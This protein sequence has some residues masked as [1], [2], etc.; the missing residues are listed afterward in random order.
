MYYPVPSDSVIQQLKETYTPG[1]TLILHSM[2][3]EPQMEFGLKGKV[4][5]VDS[6]GQIHVKWE[7][8][9]SLALDIMQD[10]FS[11]EKNV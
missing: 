8:G 5:M 11:I 1:T 7:N 6:I 2:A 9:S 10:S 4:I 3:R